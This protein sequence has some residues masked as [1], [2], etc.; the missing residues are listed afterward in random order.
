MVVQTS[1][2]DGV[3]VGNYNDGKRMRA[4]VLNLIQVEE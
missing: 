4:K 1:F 3:I 2:I